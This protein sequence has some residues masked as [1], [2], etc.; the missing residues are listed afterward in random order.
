MSIRQAVSVASENAAAWSHGIA[1]GHR[2]QVLG[3][4]DHELGGGAGTMLADDPEAVAERFLA[5]PGT[6]RTRRRRWPGLIMTRSPG[7][8][9]PTA[10][11]TASTTPA[12]SEPTMC[13]KT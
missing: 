6:R 11:P 3:R 12:P 10:G 4:N 5:R 1:G 7:R 9:A 2:R 13:G 8:T